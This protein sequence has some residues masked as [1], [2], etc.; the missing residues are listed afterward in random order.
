[1]IH[2]KLRHKIPEFIEAKQIFMS[3]T[4]SI[5]EE[6]YVYGYLVSTKCFIPFEYGDYIL[7]LNDKIEIPMKKEIF[8]Y[9][10]EVTDNENK[11]KKIN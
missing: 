7:K 1:M 3:G 11:N 2:Y 8:E 6:S 4:I 10:Y 9:L 5:P